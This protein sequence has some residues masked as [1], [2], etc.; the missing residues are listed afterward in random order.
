MSIKPTFY[1]LVGLSGSG[2]SFVAENLKG[3]YGKYI[4]IHSSDKIREELYGDARV[5]KDHGKV[6]NLLHR[7]V[8]ESLANEQHVVYDATNLSRKRRIGFLKQLEKI[9]CIKSCIIVATPFDDC[10][11]ND[12]HR[13][14]TVG[15]EVISRQREHFECPYFYEGWDAINIVNMSETIKFQELDSIVESLRAVEHDNP[16]HNLSIGE[17]MI[18]AEHYCKK[19]HDYFIKV[20]SQRLPSPLF[21]ESLDIEALEWNVDKWAIAK[22][23]ARYHDIGKGLTKRFCN[24]KGQP[25]EIAHYY[26]HHNVSA[27]EIVS[28]MRFV[29]LRVEEAPARE[30]DFDI[31]QYWFMVAALVGLHMEPFFRKDKVWEKFSKMIGNDLAEIL[32]CFHE[33]DTKADWEKD[34]D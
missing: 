16:H 5:Q 2:K 26:N 8:R 3:I 11:K 1:M 12:L 17:H 15:E 23:V 22:S 18:A 27:Y 20:Y 7:R 19:K 6:F 34:D 21:K 10:V 4:D 33:A 24:T 13:E 31:D 29:E 14:R 9:D 32:L 25:T 30:W 28:R